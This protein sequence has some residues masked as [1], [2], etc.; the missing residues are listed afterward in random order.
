[1][2]RDLFV[3]LLGQAMQKLYPLGLWLHA[4]CPLAAKKVYEAKR[5]AWLS[6]SSK[7]FNSHNLMMPVIDLVELGEF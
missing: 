7:Q 1:M 3:L 5:F 2:L 6:K 4:L